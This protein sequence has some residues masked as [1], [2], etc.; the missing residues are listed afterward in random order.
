[1]YPPGCSAELPLTPR[2]EC[3]TAK[4]ATSRPRSGVFAGPAWP[5]FASPAVA[6]LGAIPPRPPVAARAAGEAA[7]RDG[8]G[9]SIGFKTSRPRT[10]C[11]KPAGN[12]HAVQARASMQPRPTRR[13]GAP[14]APAPLPITV[15]HPPSSPPA[16]PEPPLCRQPPHR[17]V[18]SSRTVGGSSDVVLRN[19][20]CSSAFDFC[21]RTW[22]IT[23]PT[24]RPL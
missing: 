22:N 11:N 18:W 16:H 8:S 6:S 4:E 10:S 12:R 2:G 24:L 14:S 1:M 5:D 13:Q 20:A 23:A 17:A 19:T 3:Q 7:G 9:N 15:G 21:C